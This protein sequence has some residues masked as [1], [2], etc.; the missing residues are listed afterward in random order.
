MS[1][2]MLLLALSG[3]LASLLFFF[4]AWFFYIPPK[5]KPD[6]QL[7]Q[8]TANGNNKVANHDVEKY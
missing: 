2:F 1:R 3:K 6:E 7:P 8:L 4:L 5:V